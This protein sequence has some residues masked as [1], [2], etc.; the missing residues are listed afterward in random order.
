MLALDEC[1]T[2]LVGGGSA[3]GLENDT[4]I[5]YTPA[6]VPGTYSVVL[7]HDKFLNGKYRAV[8]EAQS[9][10]QLPTGVHCRKSVWVA[11][12]MVKDY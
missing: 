7:P 6:G 9:H 11:F 1:R 2:Y 12:R 3:K 8:G 10:E 4:S 5:T